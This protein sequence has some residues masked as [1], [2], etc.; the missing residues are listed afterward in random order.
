[1]LKYELGGFR[2]RFPTVV[3]PR[4]IPGTTHIDGKAGS[5]WAN[6]TNMVEDAA[7]IIPPVLHPDS[8]KINPLSINVDLDAGD[9]I[10]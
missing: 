4:Y 6:N 8:G 5:S 9:G 10:R 2:L 7:R 3:A 1:V